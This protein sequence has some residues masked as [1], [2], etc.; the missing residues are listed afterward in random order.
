MFINH[1]DFTPDVVDFAATAEDAAREM[2]PLFPLDRAVA[3]NPFHGQSDVPIALVAAR[4]ERAAGLRIFPDRAHHAQRVARG[5]ITEADIERAI[6]ET[7]PEAGLTPSAVRAALD[8]AR[9]APVATPTV[10]DL[11]A[12][13]T[14]RD[15][16]GIVTER[17]GAWAQ[18]FFDRGQ[19]LW[20]RAPRPSAW[21]DWRD[22]AT[23]DLTPE[24]LGCSGF[25][26]LVSQTDRN[27]WRALGEA[28]K[29][30]GIDAAT[31]PAVFRRL[32]WD[33]G[34]WSGH[35]RHLSW[36]AELSGDSDTT[37]CELLVIRLVWEQALY[38]HLGTA[39]AERWGEACQRHR[40]PVTPGTDDLIDAIL[41]RAA[42]VASGRRLDGLLADDTTVDAASEV[43]A[44]LVFCIDVR[45]ERFRR[46]LEEAAPDIRTH[47]V[48]GFFG[49]TLKHRP[50]ASNESDSHAPVLLKPE[51]DSREV[52]AD[53]AL[54]RIRGRAA[55]AVS[56]FSRAA[57]SS[58]AF[59]EAAGPLRIGKLFTES[60]EPLPPEEAHGPAPKLAFAATAP[61]AADAAEAALRTMGLTQDF[62]PMV[63][64]VG[65]EAH[66]K[67]D[68]QAGLLQCGACGGHSGATNARALAQ[69][70]NETPVRKSL[71]ARGIEIPAE[72]VFRAAVHDTAADRV[73]IFNKD[74][75]GERYRPSVKQLEVSLA[76]AGDAVRTERARALPGQ[77]DPED[78]LRRGMDWAQT[79]VEWGLAGCSWFVAA[80][81]SATIGRNLGGKAFLHDYDAAQDPDG[82]WLAQILGGPVCVAAWINLQYYGATVTPQ[83]FGSGNKLLH[84]V[85]GGFGILEGTSGALRGGP[86]VQST[87]LGD[88]AIHEPVRLSVRIA[89][90]AATLE[91]ALEKSPAIKGMQKAGWIDL[92]PIQALAVAA[93]TKADLGAH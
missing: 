1:E 57:V 63:V 74:Y 33:L 2:A 25:A 29:A 66:V 15:W 44:Q 81:R 61:E 27:P 80:P 91:A 11:A 65:H 24:I 34:G 8:D 73:T 68:A 4:L 42:E 53:E 56:R 37:L 12:A 7:A 83:A 79:R 23:H 16:P 60:T 59:V 62:A 36:E 67:N 31:A 28:C 5:S 50:A 58:F 75:F 86:S 6:A 51:H 87:I 88:R 14:G 78:L 47:G 40:Q 9:P 72:T 55:R 10:A 52:R 46:V 13:A 18:S 48:A 17:I 54:R 38:A 90:P 32:L 21:A 92:R 30:L 93:R 43:S 70:L 22:W 84:N 20:G 89:A 85:A 64:F 41:L 26:E 35:A 71:V 77:P 76:R 19:A 39:V 3:V 69:L 82:S 49:L 45:S